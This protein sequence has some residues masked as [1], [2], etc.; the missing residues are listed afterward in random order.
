MPSKKVI[1]IGLKVN[2]LRNVTFAFVG[3][4]FL[5]LNFCKGEIWSNV[6]SSVAFTFLHADFDFLCVQNSSFPSLSIG[7]RV[8]KLKVKVT[9]LCLN[10]D[11]E[12][13]RKL[14]VFAGECSA[15]LS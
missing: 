4:F 11:Y 9:F 6:V 12:H 13:K 2:V 14:E 8:R 15:H 5:T 7:N 1:L 3:C 10:E